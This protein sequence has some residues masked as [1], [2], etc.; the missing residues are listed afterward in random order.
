M[1]IM[2]VQMCIDREKKA[3]LPGHVLTIISLI[4]KSNLNI[5]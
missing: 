1:N 3:G 4:S 2:E 5:L